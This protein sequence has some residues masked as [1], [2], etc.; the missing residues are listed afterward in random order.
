MWSRV[1]PCFLIWCLPSV[2]SNPCTSAE[3]STHK[4][5]EAAWSDC[6]GSHSQLRRLVE[7]KSLYRLLQFL[8]PGVLPLKGKWIAVS[9]PEKSIWLWVFKKHD[10]TRVG[11]QDGTP[12][13]AGLVV[14][15]T[16]CSSRGSEFNSQQLNGDSQPFILGSNALFW[17]GGIHGDRALIYI[18]LIN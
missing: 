10:D 13:G 1:H 2:F 12:T 3:L 15:S 17:H 11:D 9:N 5:H 16:G 7:Q 8:S 14:R 6:K 18:K 4:H